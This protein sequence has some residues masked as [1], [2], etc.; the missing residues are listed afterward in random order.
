VTLDTET[1][2]VP[3]QRQTIPI[4]NNWNRSS[5]WARVPAARLAYEL[6]TS[7]RLPREDDPAP[8]Y[9]RLA[10]A[11]TWTAVLGIGGLV[12]GAH[13]AFALFTGSVWWY[14]PAVALVGLCGIG[15]TVGA[16]TSL[17][18]RRLPFVLL[19]LASV[20]LVGA[21]LLSSI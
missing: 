10:W 12:V 2:S 21:L 7:F 8:T 3:A 20:V 17:H 18:Q 1:D 9:R 11:C 15:C 19:G 14:E 4:P 13:A 16:L 5:A 6:A